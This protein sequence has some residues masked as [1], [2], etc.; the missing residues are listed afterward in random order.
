MS[1][2]TVEE[3]QAR[4]PALIAGLKP[5]QEV[6]ITLGDRPVARLVGEPAEFRPPRRPGSAVGQLAVVAEDEEH[7]QDF[8][9][10][11]P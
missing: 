4:L 6:V 5:G 10:Y 7:L 11:M 9:E 2:V 1:T 8:T 3:A